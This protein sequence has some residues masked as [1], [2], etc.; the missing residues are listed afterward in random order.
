MNVVQDVQSLVAVR[1]NEKKFFL[2]KDLQAVF[3]REQT[4]FKRITIQ[5]EHFPGDRFYRFFI[6]TFLAD[7]GNV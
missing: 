5:T 7:G 4:I 6:F 1:P 3:I 2:R